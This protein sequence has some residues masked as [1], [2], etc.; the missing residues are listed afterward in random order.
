VQLNLKCLDQQPSKTFEA[1][2]G[3]T[4]FMN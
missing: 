1:P 3:K 4:K 2:I